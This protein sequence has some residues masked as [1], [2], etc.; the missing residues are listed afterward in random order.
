MFAIAADSSLRIIQAKMP[1]K[2]LRK[3]ADDTAALLISWREQS[4]RLHRNMTSYSNIA[5]LDI[6]TTKPVGIP[7]CDQSV[8][9][10]QITMAD[11]IYHELPQNT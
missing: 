4:K 1:T 6:T 3:F 9:C 5:T 2:H 10:V 7:L 8:E 11:L